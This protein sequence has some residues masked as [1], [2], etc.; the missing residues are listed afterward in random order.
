LNRVAHHLYY[1]FI[2]GFVPAQKEVLT[3]LDKCFTLSLEWGPGSAGDYLEFGVFKGYSFW[4]AQRTAD[5]LGLSSTRF[6]GFDSFEGLPQI[7]GTDRT[8]HGEFYEGQYKC[9]QEQ[10]IRNLNSKGVDWT[11]TFLVKGYF[12]DTLTPE[13]KRE[14]QIKRVRVALIDCDLYASTVEVLN[15]LGDLL[16][17]GSLLIFDDWNCFQGDDNKGQRRALREFLE[18]RT[19]VRAIPVF[20]YGHYGQVFR[21]SLKS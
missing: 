11:R 9:S 16:E 17:E 13:L 20:S 15:F 19:G 18:G 1:R 5:R 10:V 8:K 12:K 6:F 7:E 2:H 21:I 4:F 3:A 14:H